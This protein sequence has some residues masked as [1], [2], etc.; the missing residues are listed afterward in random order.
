MASV[1]FIQVP[2][3][4]S[5]TPLRH[6]RGL[7]GPGTA[8]CVREP[9]LARPRGCQGSVWWSDGRFDGM[10]WAVSVGTGAMRRSRK[11]RRDRQT[12]RQTDRPHGPTSPGARHTGSAAGTFVWSQVRLNQSQLAVGER[13]LFRQSPTT[14]ATAY[15]QSPQ[16]RRSVS[17]MGS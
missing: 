2:W 16:S 13:Q 7:Y 12:D 5:M 17:P 14:G 6:L 11:Q 10:S 1:R 4:C 15:S 3:S 9:G 8:T